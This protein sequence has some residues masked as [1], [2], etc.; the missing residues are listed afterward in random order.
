MRRATRK[1]ILTLLLVLW[2]SSA[3][4]LLGV[5][6]LTKLIQVGRHLFGEPTP[7]ENE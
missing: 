4:A 6:S 3:F 5:A 2:P 1:I 7:S